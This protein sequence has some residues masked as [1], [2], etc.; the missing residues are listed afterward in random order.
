MREQIL[1]PESRMSEADL[2]PI[3]RRQHTNPELLSLVVV[4][5]L[6]S[7][8]VMLVMLMMVVMMMMKLSVNW[9]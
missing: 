3:F 5:L 4:V 7:L 9:H 2:K 1:N 6:L 8:Q